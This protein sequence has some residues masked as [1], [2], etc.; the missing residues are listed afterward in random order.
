M[1]KFSAIDSILMQAIFASLYFKKHRRAY[2]YTKI[3][4]VTSTEKPDTQ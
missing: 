4:N 3:L 1:T 2:Q